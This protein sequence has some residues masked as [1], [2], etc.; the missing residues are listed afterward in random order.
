MKDKKRMAAGYILL[1]LT[2]AAAAFVFSN[3]LKPANASSAESSRLLIHVNSFFSQLGLKPI[4]ENLLRKTAHFC[5]FGMLG[6]LASSTAAMLS[7]AYS[8]ASL[9]S[10]RRRGFFISFG[11]SVACAV[12]DETIQYFVPG[13]ACRVTDMLIDSAGALCGLAAVLAL[14]AAIRVRRRRRRN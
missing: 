6:I 8:A 4:S 9:P 10:L 11:V 14:C 5:E 13:R 2:V 3:S 7:G 1:A 12:C